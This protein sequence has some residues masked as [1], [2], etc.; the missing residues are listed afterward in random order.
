M[1]REAAPRPTATGQRYARVS[2]AGR[3]VGAKRACAHH[4][5]VF[6]LLVLRAGPQVGGEILVA[7]LLRRQLAAQLLLPLGVVGIPGERH[8]RLLQRLRCVVDRRV[9]GRHLL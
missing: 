6:I 4:F 1:R 3:V 7:Q 2:S 8:T 5:L 9:L